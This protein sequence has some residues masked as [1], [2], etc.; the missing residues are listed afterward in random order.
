[1]G[2]C[3]CV[4]INESVAQAVDLKVKLF[5]Q[6]KLE[7]LIEFC[8]IFINSY[9][10][11]SNNYILTVLSCLTEAY[12]FYNLNNLYKHP[13]PISYQISI[14]FSVAINATCDALKTEGFECA[15]YIV[16]ISDREKVY[17]A[18]KKVKEEIGKVD[19]LVSFFITV[20]LIYVKLN[21]LHLKVNNAGIV[22]CRP[23]LDLP[24]KAIESTY[25]VNILSH[26][27]VGSCTFFMFS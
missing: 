21:V 9:G 22:T 20:S 4:C 1:M 16:D 14:K 6:R 25:A 23:F 3:V 17:E 13:A 27:W 8:H 19:I 12:H 15:S 18:A 24:D 5:I 2:N 10:M 11:L 26:Y 7:L